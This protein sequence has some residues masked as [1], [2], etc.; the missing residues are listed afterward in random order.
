MK[1]NI[2]SVITLL[3]FA[4]LFLASSSGKETT[5]STVKTYEEVKK[6]DLEP[7]TLS[8]ELPVITPTNGTIQTQKKGGVTIT[9]EVI[10]FDVSVQ[11]N[12]KTEIFYADPKMPGY[13]VFEV[14]HTPF[15]V[16]KP[17]NFLLKIKI[18]NNQERILKIRET[19][20]LMQV[21]GVNYNMPE[22][23]IKE[24]YAGM[25]IKNA[26][27]TYDI[28]GP[29]L[30]S[31]NGAK[32]V[33][34]FINDVPTVMDEGG[35][36]KKRDNFE[37]YF[38]VKKQS[39]QKETQKTYTYQTAPVHTQQC[40]KCSGTGVDPNTTCSRCKGAGKNKNSIDGRMYECSTC[41]GTGSVRRVCN[42][43][44][45]KGALAFPKSQLPPE[46]SS[47]SWSGWAVN[48]VTN[49]PGAIVKVVNPSTKKYYDAGTSNSTVN[50]NTSNSTSYPIIV[51]YQGKS[52][53][54][55]PYDK[56]GKQIS[57]IVID[58]AGSQPTIKEGSLAN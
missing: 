44:S 9:C 28:K 55:L 3:L 51:E 37:W 41:R 5:V 13:D 8:Y 54:V 32:L 2:Y 15:A 39:A 17:E 18:K 49:P 38:E 30:N 58:F 43:C 57:K 11:E 33:Y 29:L 27:F 36:I 31:L 19:A 34:L 52:I 24:W 4:G 47:T 7:F 23:D 20:L 48:V 21:D 35:N 12:V 22:A 40:D 1:N 45:G 56:K 16:V 25:V 6:R 46:T 42:N 50:W 14:S 53:K 10:P 26:E